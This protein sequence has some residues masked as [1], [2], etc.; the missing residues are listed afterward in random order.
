MA[1]GKDTALGPPGPLAGYTLAPPAADPRAQNGRT[2]S[3]LM[4][5][6]LQRFVCVRYKNT[7]FYQGLLRI[8]KCDAGKREKCKNAV[9]FKGGRGFCG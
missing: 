8:S 7:V 2:P 5:R 6:N 4:P 1:Y 3:S 9:F